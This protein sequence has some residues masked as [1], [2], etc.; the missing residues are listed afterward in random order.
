MRYSLSDLFFMQRT[1][2]GRA[3]TVDGIKRKL[4]FILY[5]LATFYRKFFI[6]KIILIG[7]TGSLGK[8]TTKCAISHSLGLE[9]PSYTKNFKSSVA[10][11]IL[12]LRPRL[13]YSVIEMGIDSPGLMQ[14]YAKMSRPD[15]AVITSVASE[16][17]RSMH[18]L[19]NTRDEKAKLVT[20]MESSKIAILNGDDELVLEIKNMTKARVITFGHA[21]DCDIQLLAS[22]INW[23]RETK[24]EVR[25]A[26]QVI[27]LATPLFGEPAKRA[28]LSALA[29]GHALGIA[30][31]QICEKLQS[32]SGVPGRLQSVKLDSGAILIRD[33]FKST[34]ESI[35]VALDLLEQIPA[36]RKIVVLGQ[37]S[38]P[39]G[40]MGP[41]Y[42]EIG[43]KIAGIADRFIVY[44]GNFQRYGA[45]VRQLNEQSLELVD[46]KHD[47]NLVIDNLRD[48]QKGD[49]V[50][51]KGRDNERLDRV[52]LALQGIDVKCT[53]PFCDIRTNRCET[54]P[55]LETGW[56]T[57]VIF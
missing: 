14:K 4:W 48:L 54:C 55:M 33:D 18:S 8:T 34:L 53:L 7:I 31:Q 39:P 23:P 26:G 42:R 51:V 41:I 19:E 20:G 35:H 15:I 5:P 12:K 6:K 46:V 44:G 49:V 9:K 32:F 38:E 1:T 11:N 29:V 25:I 56:K 16:H 2:L 52:S 13:K 27:K 28:F 17:M 40:S 47:L 50:L 37:V 36:K 30:P 22:E 3:L 10:L 45:G 43:R 57:R 21:D 24:L